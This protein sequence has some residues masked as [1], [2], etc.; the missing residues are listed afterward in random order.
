MSEIIE[1]SKEANGDTFPGWF[2]IHAM[3][4]HTGVHIKEAF[5]MNNDCKIEVSLVIN[6]IE[7]PVKETLDEMNQ[8]M[9]EMIRRKAVELLSERV[10][11]T[12]NI[13]DKIE[14]HG[15]T[16]LGETEVW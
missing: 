6:G 1:M 13:L 14:A 2:L 7:V 9:D 12:M 10:G 8:Q 11:D 15:K 16:L 5:N 3:C 4:N